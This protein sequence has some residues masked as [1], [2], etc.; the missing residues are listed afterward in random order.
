MTK[1]WRKYWKEKRHVRKGVCDDFM[2]IDS[3]YI[4]GNK[5]L[6][7]S[8]CKQYFAFNNVD[9]NSDRILHV[10]LK[11]DEFRFYIIEYDREFIICV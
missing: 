10:K 11:N 4:F 9:E 7:A 5:Q 8:S 1:W 6:F 3:F 2:G